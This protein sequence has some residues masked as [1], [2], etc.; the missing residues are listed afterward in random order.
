MLI[1]NLHPTSTHISQIENWLIEEDNTTK[2]GFY[3]NWSIISKAF[4]EGNIFVITENDYAIGFVVYALFESYAKIDIAEVMPSMRKKGIA[5]KMIE[6]SL[7]YFKKEGALVCQ[8][9]CSPV[10]SEP[11]WKK[12]NFINFP[13]F[14][15]DDR[16][17]MFKPLIECNKP[18]NKAESNT[19]ICLW[20]CEPYQASRVEA[21]WFWDLKFEKDNNTLVSPIIFPV[22]KNWQVAITIEGKNVLTTKVKRTS[23][24]SMVHGDIMIIQKLP[25]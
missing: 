17:N 14:E 10:D 13:P 22:S 16:V 2:S 23:I 11:F 21:K 4:K 7:A 24:D 15:Y 1:L 3:C 6:E 5:R 19:T 20:D 9:F 8:L 12:M 25:V 18:K